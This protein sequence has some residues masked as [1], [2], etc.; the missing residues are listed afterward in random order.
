MIIYFDQDMPLQAGGIRISQQTVQR[1]LTD[2]WH[3]PWYDG[4]DGSPNVAL[5]SWYGT[6][7][8]DQ[9]RSTGIPVVFFSD[10]WWHA[11]RVGTW[12]DLVVFNTEWLRWNSPWRV[13]WPDRT[14]RPPPYPGNS[15]V[16]HPPVL[17]GDWNTASPGTREYVTL[18][19]L[20]D[21]KGGR[22]FWRL[23][24][25]MPH[26]KFLGVR[27]AYG[28]QVHGD[29]PNVTVLDHLS[30]HAL[31]DRVYARTQVLLLPSD[32]TYGRVL[33]ESSF[34]G[35]PTRI[36]LDNLAIRETGTPYVPM[37]NLDPV[38]WLG[39]I[40]YPDQVMH[41]HIP[42]SRMQM[43]RFEAILYGLIAMKRRQAGSVVLLD[44]PPTSAPYDR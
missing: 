18:V 37:P 22:L 20:A 13:D 16:L 7:K 1:W 40:A 28:K 34:A 15:Y 9:F 29:L 25:L 43:E 32:E 31:A 3:I 41:G 19:N 44:D 23:A 39:A 11:A 8:L 6:E 14:D 38:D 24:E 12:A 21:K 27:G 30:P 4:D 10:S 36:A 33:V 17:P 2:R 35:V 42:D 26:Q 5:L